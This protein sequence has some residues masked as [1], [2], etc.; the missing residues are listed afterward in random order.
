[1]ES[2]ILTV[3]GKLWEGWTEM[4]V[5]RSLKAIAG[6]FELSVTTRWSAAAPRVIREGQP[7]TV[8]LGADTVLTGY[9]D[10]F[11]PGYEAENV[12]IRVM[13]R[14]KT[15]DLVDCSVVHSSGKWK[16]VRLEQVAADVCRPFG[17]TVITETPTGEAFASVVLEQGETGFELLDRLAKQRGV[18][19]TSDGAGNLIIT[20]AS[21]VRA[22]V[23]LVL[24]KIS[25]PPVGASAGGSVTASTSSRAPPVPVANCGTASLPRWW[26]VAST[27]PKPRKL[28]VTARAFWSM[29]TA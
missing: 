25:S 11:I 4:S 5:S 24:G 8:R 16:G 2:V 17:I 18:L 3:D 29:K 22:G 1:M 28:T 13:G 6:E 26:A 21:S 12:E 27:S 15:G 14:D 23:S 7:C 20:R 10:D 19:L 9:I